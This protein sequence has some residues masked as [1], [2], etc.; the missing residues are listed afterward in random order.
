MKFVL[1]LFLGCLL[2]F[3]A[4]AQK[5][6]R[7]SAVVNGYN[8]KVVDFE[9][10]DNPDNNMQYPYADGKRMEFEVELKEPSLM[11][12]NRWVWV[13]VCPGDEIHAEVAYNGKNVKTTR[14]SGSEQAVLLNQTVQDA[15]DSRISI[16]YKMNPLAAVVTLIPVEKYYNMSREQWKKE[17]GMLEAVKDKVNAEAYRYIYSELEGIFLSNLVNYPFIDA[18]VNKKG[19]AELPAGYWNVLDGYQVRSDKASLKSFSYLNWLLAYKEYCDRRTA[20]QKGETFRY[21]SDLQKGFDGL[22]V[23]YQGEALDAAL[24]VYLYNAITKQQDFAKISQLAK[25]YYKKY[26]HTKTYKTT[27]QEMMK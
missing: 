6:A 3:S 22:T 26:N 9:F 16:H 13:I 5:T 18:D 7:I 1:T 11:K 14:F 25:I 23:F 4:G 12:L 24:Y 20:Q 27:L 19:Q 15:R 2:A 17:S 21:E 10:I 8:G